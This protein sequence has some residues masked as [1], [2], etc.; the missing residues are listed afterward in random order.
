M[1]LDPTIECYNTLGL[2]L[3]RGDIPIE[4]G[5]S[6]LTKKTI[7]VVVLKRK[8]CDLTEYST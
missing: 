7:Q 2:T 1:K 5:D 8:K 3:I 4:L 6:W